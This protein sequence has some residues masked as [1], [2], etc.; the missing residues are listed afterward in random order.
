MPLTSVA[1]ILV[2]TAPVVAAGCAGPSDPPGTV[3][4]S[5]GNL[6]SVSI[7]GDAGSD[8]ASTLSGGED[9]SSAGPSASGGESN[10]STMAPTWTEIYTADLQNGTIGNC[11]ICHAQMSTAAGA[12][13]YLQSTGFINGRGS[14]LVKN[15]S[16]LSWYGGNMPPGGTRSNAMVVSRM[17]A[18]ATAGAMNN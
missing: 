1:A 12:Y 18:W 7:D 2:M 9:T 3:P 14:L 17:N 5:Q 15:G 16:C 4:P 8:D 11:V 10:S 6:S 13:A